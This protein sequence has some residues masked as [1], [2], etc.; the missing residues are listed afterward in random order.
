MQSSTAPRLTAVVPPGGGY[1]VELDAGDVLTI[2][3]VAGMQIGDMVLFA[4]HDPTER[5]SQAATRLRNATA[6]GDQA[7]S[8][9]ATTGFLLATVV[10]DDV[11]ANDIISPACHPERYAKD[12]RAPNHPS[13]KSSILRALEP[14]EIDPDL[15]PDPFNVFMRTVVMDGWLPVIEESPSAAGSVFRLRAE[16]PLIFATSSCPQD[17]FAANGYEITSLEIEVLAATS[18]HHS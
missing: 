6:L 17:F 14:F 18:A 16:V 15:F 9:Y 1:A 12:F 13:C 5:F 3:D 11:T 10:S 4:R 7:T 2:R 8:L